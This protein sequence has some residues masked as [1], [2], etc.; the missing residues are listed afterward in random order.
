MFTIIHT[1]TGRVYT[2]SPITIELSGFRSLKRAVETAEDRCAD[3]GGS[4]V[5]VQAA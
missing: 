4:Y 2:A 5:I 1:Y 3:F